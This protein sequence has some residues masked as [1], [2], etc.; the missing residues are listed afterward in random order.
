V[1][2]VYQGH[3]DQ[4]YGPTT[5][6]QHGEDLFIVN[7]FNLI[8]IEKPTYLDIGAHHPFHISNTALLYERGSRGVNV[9]ANP[10]LIEDFYLHRPEDMDVCAGVI[11]VLT[12]STAKF[13][14]YDEKSGRN[15]FSYKEVKEYGKEIKQQIDVEVF[16]INEIVHDY[17]AGV[18]PHFLSIDIEGFDF[19][20][21]ESADFR[22]SS[23]IVI[24]VETRMGQSV[25]ARSFMRE[26]GYVSVARMGENLI[27]V[28]EDH[29]KFLNW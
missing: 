1:K 11:P 9:E 21:L 26:R 24:C 29:T 6:S 22:T 15:T 8:G 17:C 12:Q 16:T 18:F 25:S 10:N 13:L 4:H 3:P 20:V 2:T 7:L 19:Q 28:R 23:P 5:Y 14:M 27:F